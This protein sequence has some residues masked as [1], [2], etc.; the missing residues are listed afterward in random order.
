MTRV[1]YPA[2]GPVESLVIRCQ[3]GCRILAKVKM[4]YSNG[5]ARLTSLFPI[6]AAERIHVLV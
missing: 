5:G 6:E 4:L 2:L 1:Q 3:L